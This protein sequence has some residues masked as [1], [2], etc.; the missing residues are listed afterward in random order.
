MLL[1][2]LKILVMLKMQLL[3]GMATTSMDTV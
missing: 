2:S 1:L 3:D